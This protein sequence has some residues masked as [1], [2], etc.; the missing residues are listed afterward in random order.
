MIRKITLFIF[1][2]SKRKKVIIIVI[3][4]ILIIS[5]C[6]VRQLVQ[7]LPYV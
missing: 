4:N 7:I 6:E 3:M 2:I 5:A 1:D